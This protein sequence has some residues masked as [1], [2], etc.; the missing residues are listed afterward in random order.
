VTIAELT[1]D[2]VDQ[3]VALFQRL[4]D[5]DLTFIKEDVLDPASVRSW[6]DV[7]GRQ[8]IW[9]QGGVLTGYA[10]LRPLSGWSDHVAELRLVVDPVARRRG[11]GRALAR[12]AVATALREGLQKVIVEVPAEQD[13]VLAMF[14]GLGFTG[15]ALLRDHF[16]DRAGTL[17]DLVM[18]AHLAD[19]TF[20]A[21]DAVGLAEALETEGIPDETLVPGTS[22]EFH[23]STGGPPG[24]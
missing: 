21:M 24:P 11:V 18:M 16:R 3:L 1:A 8:F 7:R 23:P 17:R 10:A 2:H 4:P 15:E 13:H 20:T 19:A 22:P 12:H 14:A 9:L 6:L 5:S